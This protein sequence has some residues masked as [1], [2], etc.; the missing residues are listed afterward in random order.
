MLQ[1]ERLFLI[2]TTLPMLE[3]IVEE[4]WPTL[5]ALLGGV[6]LADQW[7]HFPE[8]LYWMRDYAREHD[9]DMGWWNYLIVHR[10]DVRLIGTC[11]FKG[12]PGPDGT[13]EVGYEIAAS[14][15]RRGLGGESAQKLVEYAFTFESVRAVTA[16]TLAEENAS[17]A[18]LRKLGFQ[19]MGEQ[20]DIED[21]RVWEWR[22]EREG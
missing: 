19:F 4:D 6:D 12:A 9:T 14:Y 18:I 11:G 16:N 8:A 15:Q 17:C 1:T 13:V 10:H 21:G 20:I 2:P 5:S 3:A 7:T 22:K